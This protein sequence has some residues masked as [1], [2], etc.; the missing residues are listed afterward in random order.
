M[1][2]HTRGIYMNGVTI[3]MRVI[4]TVLVFTFENG[5]VIADASRRTKSAL[6]DHLKIT[7]SGKRKRIVYL[8]CNMP[9]CHHV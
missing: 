1:C 2:T 7:K 6:G 4:I 8:C 9:T 5:F 3:D